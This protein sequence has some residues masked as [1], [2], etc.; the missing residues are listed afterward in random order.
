MNVGAT[1]VTDYGNYY[2][3]GKGAATYQETSGDTDYSGT[4][5]PL[6]ASADTAVQEWGGSW[7]M[8]TKAQFNE[9]TAN[10]TYQWVTNY[11]NSNING[12]TFTANGQTLFIPAAGNY[13]VGEPYDVGT[14]AILWSSSPY[15]S[16]Y[17]HQAFFFGSEK[18][19]GKNRRK[20]GYPVRPVLD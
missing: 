5:T 2:Q 16:T 3:Y 6:A 9:L 17:A 13:S 20:W 4:E 18:G 1:S 12:A 11:Q 10:T 19:V 14:A 15:D 8:P 7:H